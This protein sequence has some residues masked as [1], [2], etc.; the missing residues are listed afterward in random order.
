M[1]DE[2]LRKVF[3]GNVPFNCTQEDFEKSFNSVKGF[4]KGEI[5]TKQ[6]SN[7]CRG[8]GFIT[9]NTS[10]NVEELKNRDDLF[11]NHRQL[12]FTEYT[13]GP[14]KPKS[15]ENDKNKYIY[16]N[17]IPDG[18]NREYLE[19]VFSNYSLGRHYISTDVET[20]EQ[21]N[22]GLI[23]I[24]DNLKYKEL[25]SMSTIT[26]W[27]NNELELCRWKS[28]S[29]KKKDKSTTKY[30]LFKAF[31]AGRNLGIIEGHQLAKKQN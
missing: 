7:I 26:D 19:K 5:V 2:N 4:I 10:N 15:K 9:L 29:Y 14:I 12:R 8:F 30:D 28:K 3:V 20:G 25:L 17:G 21:Q 24:L 27:D 22:N 18:N 11:I 1:S 31:T 6:H 23:E 13:N 16:V